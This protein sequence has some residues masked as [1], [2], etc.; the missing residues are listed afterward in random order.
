MP[1][2]NFIPNQDLTAV[3]DN[4]ANKE[5]KISGILRIKEKIYDE[6]AFYRIAYSD[7]LAQEVIK[8][9]K[10]S[11]IVKA[12]KDSDINVM[13]NEKIDAST[14]D[15]LID[16]LGGSDLPNSIMIYPNDFSS[17]EKNLGLS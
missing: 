5:L 15:S 1:T 2:G 17:K 8:E 4:S 3:Y 9:N 11:A 10:N 14:R 6:F 13:T 7:A 16:Y 12:Q